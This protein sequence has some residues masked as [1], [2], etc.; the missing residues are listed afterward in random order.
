VS[1]TADPQVADQ[2]LRY[3][4]NAR[5]FAGKGRRVQFRSLTPLPWLTEVSDFFRPAAAPGVRFEIA[6][7]AYPPEEDPEPLV[8]SASQAAEDLEPTQDFA[9]GEPPEMVE[10]SVTPPTEYYHLAISYRPAPHAELHQAEIARFTDPDLGPVIAY[11]AAQDPD[12]CRVILSALRGGRRLR[13]PD[14]ETRFNPTATAAFSADL[15]PRLFTGQQSNTSVM[16]G[17]TA[18]LK[19]FR[20]LELGHN[21]DIE[22]HAALNAAGISDVAGLFGWI[23]GSWVSRGLQLDADLAMVIEKLA[24]AVD[25]WELALDSLRAEN[26]STSINSEFAFAVEAQALGKALAEIHHALRSSFDTTRVLGARTAMIM[27]DRLHEAAQIAPALAPHVAG[28]LRCFDEL[29]AQTL[30]TQK[31]HGDFHLGQTLHT[32]SGWKIIDFEGE[33]AKTMAERRAPDSVW[34]DVAGMLRS[35]DYA[36]ASIPGPRSAAWAAACRAAFLHGYT[37]AELGATEARLLRA[38]EADKAIYEVVYEMRNRPDW[39][40][41]P[42]RAVADLAAGNHDSRGSDSSPT[43]AD[44]K[45]VPNEPGE[46]ASPPSEPGKLASPP[47]ESGELASPTR[48]QE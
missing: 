10:P 15:Q 24:G 18:I 7:L 6:E 19:L 33:P 48:E 2:V 20:R 41:I 14:S 25:G 26:A 42:L 13:S 30:D 35:F 37:V 46:L 47:N 5:W 17:E 39:I 28:L 8:A 9:G 23:E 22:V 32:P 16:L 31:V 38:Y 11:D 36:A 45:Q 21:L 34:R 29:G 12:A 3:I 4:S 43:F 27:M 1:G 44:I 40:S